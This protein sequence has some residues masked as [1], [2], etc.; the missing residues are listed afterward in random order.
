MEKQK[1]IAQTNTKLCVYT[2]WYFKQNIVSFETNFP[3][4]LAILE[5]FT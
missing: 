2:Y 4:A 1:G 5:L 3:V